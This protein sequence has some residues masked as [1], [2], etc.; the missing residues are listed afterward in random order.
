MCAL[1]KGVGQ[2]DQKLR[3]DCEKRREEKKRK[4]KERKGKERKNIKYTISYGLLNLFTTPLRYLYL[5]FLKKKADVYRA[6][7][8]RR[9]DHSH[10]A[11]FS[12][13]LF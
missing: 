10:M 12:Y 7:R 3:S 4:E 9:L 1:R 2:F 11:T 5:I 8:Y 13:S 6:N